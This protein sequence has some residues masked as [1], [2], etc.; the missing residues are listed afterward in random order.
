MS[1]GLVSLTMV[2][3]APER[4]IPA[5]YLPLVHEGSWRRILSEEL[6]SVD[7][8]IQRNYSPAAAASGDYSVYTG[9]GEI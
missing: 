8:R 7:A 1:A 2:V 9:A 5:S 6:I 3:V 4:C